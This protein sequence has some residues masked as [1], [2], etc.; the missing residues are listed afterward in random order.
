MAKSCI[1]IIL[2]LLAA[3][4]TAKSMPCEGGDSCDLVGEVDESGLLVIQHTSK[5]ASKQA[6]VL[7]FT[8]TKLVAK[9][10]KCSKQHECSW[11]C[12]EDCEACLSEGCPCHWSSKSCGK[13][14]SCETKT[15]AWW[16]L[17]Q[18]TS[19]TSEPRFCLASDTAA[20]I[21]DGVLIALAVVA[22]VGSGGAALGLF[23]S[24]AVEEE[25]GVAAVSAGGMAA[26]FAAAGAVADVSAADASWWMLTGQFGGIAAA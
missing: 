21:E 1:A 2:L 20:Q 9:N 12:M 19:L 26:Q 18:D 3:R 25:G 17:N 5:Q 8:K 4:G 13:D 7:S 11:D 23:A 10:S 16:K 22:V 15:M 14:L 6:S 24:G